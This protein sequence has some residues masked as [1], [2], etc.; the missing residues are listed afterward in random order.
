MESFTNVGVLE[1]LL[2]PG[3]R[4]QFKTIYPDVP[5]EHLFTVSMPTLAYVP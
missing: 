2:L 5:E 4:L 1:I 3:N